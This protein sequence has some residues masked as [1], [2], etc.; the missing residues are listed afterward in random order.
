[1]YKI[2]LPLF[3]YNFKFNNFLYR[4]I[5]NN[6][7]SKKFDY[8]IVSNFGSYPFTY[9]NGDI[10]SNTGKLAL[11]SDFYN[12]PNSNQVVLKYDFSNIF[13]EDLDFN[14][15]H[16]NTILKMGENG[17][18]QI[19]ISNLKLMSYLK[20][21]Y[22]IYNFCFSSRADLIQ[23]FTAEIINCIIEQN[24]FD[25]IV[26]PGYLN[27]EEWLKE[28]K[29]KNKI[30]I[31]IA[32]KCKLCS[33]NQNK[34]CL[35]QENRNQIDFSGKSKYQKCFNIKNYQNSS[36]DEI[37]SEIIK[38]N[39]KGFTN[40]KIDSPPYNQI[41]EFNFFIIKNLI[42]EEYQVNFIQE[43]ERIK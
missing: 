4:Y 9:F 2:S 13:L 15:V 6:P 34:E 29:Q 14:S 33:A 36:N 7:E 16:E 38:M 20:K 27:D 39:K 25:S 22:P 37:L 17:S 18:N 31:I 5:K 26:L 28:I 42:K 41:A 35:I 21:E 30:E 24:I 32:N 11:N 1:M 10:N 23:P 43:F 40:F 3:Y 8:T 12:I 19:E